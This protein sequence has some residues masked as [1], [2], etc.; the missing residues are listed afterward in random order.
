MIYKS[1]LDNWVR[2]FFSPKLYE[3]SNFSKFCHQLLFF[4]SYFNKDQYLDMFHLIPQANLLLNCHGYCF[5]TNLLR[6]S[7]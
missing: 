7:I 1:Y 3:M 2:G 5:Q 6:A 4:A